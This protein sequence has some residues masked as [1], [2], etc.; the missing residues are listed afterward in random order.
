MHNVCVYQRLICA[1]LLTQV[2]RRLLKLFRFDAD[3]QEDI[4]EHVTP[5]AGP[6]EEIFG[7]SESIN[8]NVGDQEEILDV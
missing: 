6:D 2:T 5:E 8:D 3:V 1:Y 7:D 4:E